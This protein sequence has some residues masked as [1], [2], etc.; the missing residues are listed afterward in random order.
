MDLKGE[1]AG[2]RWTS[3]GLLSKRGFLAFLSVILVFDF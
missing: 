1:F 2:F 3:P